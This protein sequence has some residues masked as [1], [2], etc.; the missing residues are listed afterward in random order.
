MNQSIPEDLV[1]YVEEHILPQYHGFDKAHRLDHAARVIEE[2][3][4][5]A[6]LYKADLS[7][8]YVIAAYHDT[9]LCKGRELHHLVSGKILAEDACLRQWFTPE[10]LQVMKEA[11]EDHRASC[12]HE[13]GAVRQD[14]GGGRPHHRSGNHTASDRTIRIVA[15][16][17]N[18][19]RRAVRPVQGTPDRQIRSQRI[20][21]AV[22]TGIQQCHTPGRIPQRSWQM[23][24]CCA[25]RSA[26]FTKQNSKRHPQ[27]PLT[28]RQK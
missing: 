19:G 6:A 1:R 18:D 14:C 11:V 12:D 5:L 20:L 16:S 13:P 23:R 25:A 22:D 27:T 2:S 26:G 9:G 24:S 8:A 3:L 28:K 17:G 4:Q 21:A 10:Q 15:L 7:M